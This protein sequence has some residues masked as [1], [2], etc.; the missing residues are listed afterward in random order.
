VAIPL[1]YNFR[2]VRA[3]WTSSVVAILGIAGTVGVFV[4]MLSLARGFKMTLVRSGSPQNA[5]VRRA[6]ATSE[7]D[8]SVSLD[9]VKVI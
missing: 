4:A 5:I 7:V 9:Q 1:V 8:G 3:R 6:G 2:S